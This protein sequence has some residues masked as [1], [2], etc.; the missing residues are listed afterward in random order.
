MAINQKY[1]KKINNFGS[2]ILA[3]NF[4]FNFSK[5]H[6]KTQSV[7]DTLSCLMLYNCRAL[8]QAVHFNV[9]LFYWSPIY[10]KY[11]LW[12]HDH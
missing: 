11:Y 9:F 7:D 6:S 5:I 8:V 10:Y 1:E 12:N 2:E 3:N 4:K